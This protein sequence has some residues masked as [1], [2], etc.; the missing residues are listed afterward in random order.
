MPKRP[1]EWHEECLRNI[2]ASLAEAEGSVAHAEQRA[3]RLRND[4]AFYQAQI[5]AAKAQ[6]MDSFDNE[7][8]LRNR[9]VKRR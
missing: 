6:G 7:R 2:R 3:A 9:A 5:D 1:L 8:L 4:V